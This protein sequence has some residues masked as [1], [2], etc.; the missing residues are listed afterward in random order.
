MSREGDLGAAKSRN[1]SSIVIL[2]LVAIVVLCSV[3]SWFLRAG[4]AAEATSDVSFLLGP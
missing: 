1:A 3:N 4:A 2:F